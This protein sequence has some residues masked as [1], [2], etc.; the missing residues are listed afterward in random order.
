MQVDLTEEDE[1]KRV[2]ADDGTE[3]G[4]VTEVRG[5]TAYVDP[6]PSL[7]ESVSAALGWGDRDEGARP[8][9]EEQVGAV[10]DDEV[11][12]RPETDVE[13]GT[14]GPGEPTEGVTG[15]EN[16]SDTKHKEPSEPGDDLER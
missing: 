14:T 15:S 9:G 13:T 2:V 6:D 1:G 8:L 4:V 5:G 12:L 7:L 16:P 3:I 10:T 11:R